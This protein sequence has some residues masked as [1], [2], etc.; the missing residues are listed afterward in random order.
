MSNAMV[1]TDTTFQKEVIE[2]DK[3]VLVDFWAPWCGPC[4]MM[5]PV[6][7]TISAKLEAQ[8][9][10]VKLNTDENQKT[11]ET[12]GIQGIPSLLIFKKG[13]VVER[14]VGFMPENVLTEKVKP[15]LA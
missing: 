2:A 9:K 7:E 8:L 11:S 12:Y 1:V 13:E 15:H 10:V 6:L 4:R 3:P 5:A 14:L